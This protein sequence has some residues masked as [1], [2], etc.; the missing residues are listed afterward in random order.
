MCYVTINSDSFTLYRCLNNNIILY[1][2]IIIVKL[3]ESFKTISVISVFFFI[4]HLLLT[5]SSC[6]NLWLCIQTLG[7]ISHLIKVSILLAPFSLFTLLSPQ[8]PCLLSY[9]S[10]HY[11]ICYII[12]YLRKFTKVFLKVKFPDKLN[13]YDTK[14]FTG[15]LLLRLFKST[16]CKKNDSLPPLDI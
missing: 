4:C 13:L 12:V 9:Y 6:V 1:T 5:F 10:S 7:K 8:W 2:M 11:R 3:Y 15:S 16:I 14:F